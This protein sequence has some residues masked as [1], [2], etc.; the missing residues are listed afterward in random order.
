MLL[1]KTEIENALEKQGRFF[2]INEKI[3][4]SL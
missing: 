4:P 1:K 3:T 2:L